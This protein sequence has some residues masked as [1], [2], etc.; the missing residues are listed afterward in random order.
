ML[1]SIHKKLGFTIVEIIVVVSIIGIL[2]TIGVVAW[3]GI[4]ERSRNAR[5]LSA[6]TT[7]R[8]TFT[9]FA[10]QEKRYP[11]VPRTGSYCLQYG[12]LTGQEVNTRWPA[13]AK[14]L[15]LTSGSVTKDSYYCRDFL[16]PTTHYAIYPP[17]LQDIESISKLNASNKADDY[18]ADVSSGGIWVRY[19]G[20]S[21]A[22]TL[23]IH[24]FFSGSNCPAST[25]K[26]WG[27]AKK[28]ICY[29]TLDR[30]LP[31]TYTGEA[32]TPNT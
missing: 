14:P 8:D 7:Y 28:S 20:T 12:G 18:L 32:W 11:T 3:N 26:S 15:T 30:Q 21:T 5:V 24:G 19:S 13:A 6:I 27:D 22:T 10:A 25:V 2:L 1:Y 16:E 23:Q 17:L 31:A 29:I 9:F 4:Q